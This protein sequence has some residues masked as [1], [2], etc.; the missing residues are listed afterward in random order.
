MNNR[1]FLY[2]QGPHFQEFLSWS[3]NEDCELIMK[4]KVRVPCTLQLSDVLFCT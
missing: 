3:V 4:C 1:V 2:F